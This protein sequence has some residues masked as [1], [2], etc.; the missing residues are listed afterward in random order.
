MRILVL[1]L[2]ALAG[3]GAA[4]QVPQGATRATTANDFFRHPQSAK[5]YNELWGYQFVF[6]N[7]TKAFVN[8]SWMYLPQQGNKVGCD[9]SF[10]NFKGKSHSVGRQYPTERFKEDRASST[11]SIKDEYAMQNLPGKGHRVYFTA[12]KGGRF[13][14]D[15]EFIQATPGLVPGN[16]EFQVDGHRYGLYVHI[17]YGRVKG[18]I[19]YNNDTIEVQ[20]YGYMDHAWQTDQATELA[21]R[22]MAFSTASS[23][24]F[25]AGRIGLT[26]SGEPF[27]YSIY[28]ENGQSQ[29]TFAKEVMDGESAYNPKKGFP[30]NVF[31]H[32]TQ[33]EVPVLSFDASKRQ[34]K[35]SILSNFDGWLAQKAARFMMGGELLFIRGRSSSSL[36]HPVD[37]AFTGF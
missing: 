2:I 11:I 7:G 28:R 25:M 29:I 18:K 31:I 20:G 1:V 21:A 14:V 27:G 9:L 17:P 33:P 24:K 16:G 19:A 6:D 26:S 30:K 5:K 12:D 36:G 35:F 37:W 8:Y 3:A 13:L 23:K 34:Q 15:V 22:Y 32:W 10:W 4:V